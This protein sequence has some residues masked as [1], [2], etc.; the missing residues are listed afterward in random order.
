MGETWVW[1]RFQQ[2]R[3]RREGV[4][5]G[6]VKS[7][8]VQGLSYVGLKTEQVCLMRQFLNVQVCVRSVLTAKVK[9]EQTLV[10]TN[11]DVSL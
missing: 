1:G 11:D 2:I 6:E 4:S 8:G 5:S 7:L 10:V 3:I 9:T